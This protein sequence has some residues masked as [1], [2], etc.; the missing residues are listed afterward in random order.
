[1]AD[2]TYPIIEVVGV[3][4]DSIHQAVRNAFIEARIPGFDEAVV[5]T[6]GTDGAGPVHR[7]H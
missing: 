1:M 3:S 2:H 4:E 7:A 5:S 6:E